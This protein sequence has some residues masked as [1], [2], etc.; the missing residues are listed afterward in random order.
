[1]TSFL[2][3]LLVL[4]LIIFL[5]FIRSIDLKIPV[6]S[7]FELKR[8]SAQGDEEASRQL[9]NLYVV[10]QLSGALKLKEVFIVTCLAITIGSVYSM[11]S[12]LITVLIWIVC[13][14]LANLSVLRRPFNSY[15]D[16]YRAK[17]VGI[18]ERLPWLKFYS[19]LPELNS[20][21]IASRSELLHRAR[22]SK[23]LS[24]EEST[25]LDA[26]LAQ[27]Y[28][29]AQNIMIDMASVDQVEETEPLG[30]L[31]LDTLHKTGHQVFPVVSSTG[32]IVGILNLG[33]DIDLHMAKKRA[34]DCMTKD[35]GV[36]S[37]D[38]PVREVLAELVNTHRPLVVVVD[39]A[40]V[41]GIVFLKDA[42]EAVTGKLNR[43]SHH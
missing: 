14:H 13:V 9:H 25:S 19:N 27:G 17:A 35:F 18:I 38:L 43:I 20:P 31:T 6:H 22:I 36:V 34:G 37:V 2:F 32:S 4:L 26:L 1:M 21:A 7:R 12:L 33:T 10:K 15:F 30:P 3:D 24:R 42:I 23:L 16:K 11:W 5:V 8:R 39:G 29:K 28:L 41:V 40:D